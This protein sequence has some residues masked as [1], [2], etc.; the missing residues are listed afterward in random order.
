MKKKAAFL[1]IPVLA[2]CFCLASITA[3]H[4]Q[5]S[6][7]VSLGFALLG[8]PN[9]WMAVSTPIWQITQNGTAYSVPWVD[10]AANPRFAIYDPGSIK[11]TDDVVLD[12]ETGLVWAR[13]A[14]LYGEMFWTDAAAM[15]AGTALGDR[16]GWRIPTVSELQT[17]LDPSAEDPAL[18][19]GHPFFN[20]PDPDPET[21]RTELWTSTPVWSGSDWVVCVDINDGGVWFAPPTGQQY[22]WVVRGG[23]G[24]RGGN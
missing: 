14:N 8:I 12:K 5:W 19:S 6:D 7:P 18:P 10:H 2:A 9:A 17:L 20:L 3:A 24:G 22:F 16:F 15:A 13:N 1:G 23:N 11:L 21:G 4:A